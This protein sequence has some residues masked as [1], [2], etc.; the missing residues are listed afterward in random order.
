MKQDFSALLLADLHFHHL[1]VWH[2]EWCEKFVNDLLA[3][4]AYK[5][6]YLFLLGDA[7]EIR[8]RVDARVLN[9]L[10]KLI[11]N[12]PMEV[13]YVTGQHDS[14][15]PGRG[16]IESIG[17]L[18]NVIVVDRDVYHHE[19]TDTWFI[20]FCR[21]DDDYRTLLAK[22]PDGATVFTHLPIMEAIAQFHVKDIQGIELKDFARFDHTYSGDIHT[23]VDYFGFTYVGA[24]KQRDWRDKNVVGQ[25]GLIE[26]GVFRRVPTKHPI[27]IQVENES[28][29]P[30]GVD[31]IVKCKRGISTNKENVL[32]S[33]EITSIDLESIELTSTEGTTTE[34]MQR[35]LDEHVDEIEGKIDSKES[36]LATGETILRE[37]NQ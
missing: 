27:H 13:V 12:W 36:V 16:T 2:Q 24:V 15:A 35:Y 4:A 25:I 22:I 20:P 34:I 32:A 37:A 19:A 9:L 1:P 29:I 17:D 3:N 8:D 31:C 21:K 7:L 33:V 5:G 10:L 28:E 26:N 23:F 18:P 14:Y 11:V 30:D 6:H